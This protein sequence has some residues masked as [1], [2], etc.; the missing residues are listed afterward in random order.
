MTEQTFE[1]GQIFSPEYPPEAAEF[2]NSRGDC[3]ITE[4]EPS[5]GKRRFQIVA[6]PEPTEEEL[7][8]IELRKQKQLRA[9]KVAATR[10]VVDGMTFDGDETAQSR[11]ARAIVAAE[12]A[13]RDTTTWVLADNTVATVTKAQLQQALAKSMLAMEEVWPAPY[14]SAEAETEEP[15]LAK[16]GIGDAS[17]P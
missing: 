8:A 7:A 12:T 1:I 17:A 14:E 10:V 13:G 16:V 4:L 2:C 9:E 5:D 11:M 15:S 6:V 3:Y